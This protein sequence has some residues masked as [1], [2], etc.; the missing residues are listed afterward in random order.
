MMSDNLDPR[1]C[2]NGIWRHAQK[3]TDGRE[4]VEIRNS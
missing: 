2:P 3:T 4:N 1:I